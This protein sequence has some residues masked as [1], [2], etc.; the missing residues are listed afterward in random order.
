MSSVCMK[1]H[2][3]DI[4]WTYLSL[5]E[6][7]V[8]HQIL[9]DD[10]FW[11]SQSNIW[12]P[13]K[14]LKLYVNIWRL[15]SIFAVSNHNFAFKNE[16]FVSRQI[17][18]PSV[19]YSMQFVKYLTVCIKMWHPSKFYAPSQILMSKMCP[20]KV[21]IYIIIWKV[22]LQIYDAQPVVRDFTPAWQLVLCKTNWFYSTCF[23]RHWHPDK[24][25]SE[26]WAGKMNQY[27]QSN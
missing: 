6:F 4:G 15:W 27:W 3:R 21:T 1:K 9:M 13:T 7:D 17:L 5:Y 23:M 10:K 24:I 14:K 16:H 8:S 26:R 22:P 11:C 12:G 18:T 2:S 25:K 20:T 19:K